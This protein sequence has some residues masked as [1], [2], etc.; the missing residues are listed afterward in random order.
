MDAQSKSII[1]VSFAVFVWGASFVATKI[2]LI[3]LNPMNLVWLRFSIGLV[4]LG[5]LVW[6]RGQLSLPKK[7]DWFYFAILGFLGITFHQWLQSTGLQTSQAITTGLIIATIPIFMV[8]LAW[9]FLKE[10][11]TFMQGFGI[12]LAVIGVFLVITMGK[13]NNISWGNIGKPGDLLILLS[14]PNWAV[15]SI[16]SRRG[17]RTYPAA[18]M[19]FYVMSS[20]WFFSTLAM[21][22]SNHM[23]A[24][25]HISWQGWLAIGF[26]GVFCSGFAYIFWYD[27]LQNLPVSQT[28][29]FLYLEPLI[30]IIISG[31]VLGEKLTLLGFIGGG[32]ILIGV[33]LVN[34]KNLQVNPKKPLIE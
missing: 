29:A 2:A 25:I 3:D 12:C 1:K 7:G 15:F 17:L 23:F 6:S 14:A 19:M 5:G 4:I 24:E 34:K 18:Q 20:G 16:L 21:L 13:F 30:T 22:G 28:G 27:A 8:F 11:I 10:K 32:I 31:I 9:L 26:L 33:W